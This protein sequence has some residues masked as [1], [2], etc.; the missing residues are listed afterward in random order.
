MLDTQYRMHPAISSFPSKTFYN[1]ALKDGTISSSGQLVP[2]FETPFSRYLQDD[3]GQDRNVMFIDHDYPESPE[4]KS[5]ANYGDAEIVADIVVDI[6]H[7]N[8]V[9]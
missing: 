7:N 5:I 4:T 3:Q 1:D 2:G 9:S 8:P 6:L